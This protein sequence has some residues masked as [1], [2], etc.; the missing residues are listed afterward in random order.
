MP[1]ATVVLYR[2]VEATTLLTTLASASAQGGPLHAHG[3]VLHGPAGAEAAAV[4]EV[5]ATGHGSYPLIWD[6]DAPTDV[7]GVHLLVAEA[8]ADL[9]VCEWDGDGDLAGALLSDPPCDVLLVRPGSFSAIDEIVVGAGEGPN[10]PL[11]A[12]LAR[13]WGSLFDVPVSLVRVA[14]DAADV[15]A[16]EAICTR[17]AEDVPARTPVD[18]DVVTALVDLAARSGFLALGAAE[19]V[20]LSEARIHTVAARVAQSSDA[21]LVVGRHGAAV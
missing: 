21:T 17:L 15:E 6:G 13:H 5:V 16:A 10:A 11:V 7:A 12:G 8:S 4:I 1:R 3:P 14:G 18:R 2:S 9:L 19:G 20:P